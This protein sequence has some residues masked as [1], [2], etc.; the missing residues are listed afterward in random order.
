[1]WLLGPESL[2]SRR[3]GTLERP[4]DVALLGIP[5]LL[6]I[7][8]GFFK[9]FKVNSFA[10]GRYMRSYMIDIKMRPFNVLEEVRASSDGVLGGGSLFYSSQQ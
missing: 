8:E 6:N 4:S 7:I 5:T 3:S 9:L 2:L 10:H 1:M